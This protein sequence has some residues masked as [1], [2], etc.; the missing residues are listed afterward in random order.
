MSRKRSISTDISTDTRVAQ[1]AQKAGP[2]AVLLFTWLI[3]H[4]DDWGRYTADPMQ[5]KLTVLPAFDV[6]L[7]EIDNALKVIA[8]VGLIVLYEVEG[9][10]YLSL[11]PESF[12]KYQTYIPASKRKVDNSQY[13]APP[14]NADCH[15]IPQNATDQRK[16]PQNATHFREM[17]QNVPSPSPSLSLSPSVTNVDLDT[18]QI[19][20]GDITESR[21]VKGGENQPPPTATAACV[22]PSPDLKSGRSDSDK[23]QVPKT[24]VQEVYTAEFEKFWSLYPRKVEKRAAFKAWQ[25]RLRE[26]ISSETL[27]CAA[28]YYA[29][30]CTANRL[31]E[32]YIKHPATFLGPSRPFED[33]LK[34]RA[35]PG[36]GKIRRPWNELEDDK[37]R[38]LYRLV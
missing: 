4:V 19:T 25:A 29:E 14:S 18:N 36:V 10:R 32:R 6:S 35:E 9:K 2:L 21:G 17:P 7:E 38:D 37:Y 26:G 3:P 24:K 33:Y 27:I 1:L 28:G 16:P 11:R 23:L 22:S 5:V 30:Y 34:P 8:E 13:P 12:Y 15:A 31:E 20:E